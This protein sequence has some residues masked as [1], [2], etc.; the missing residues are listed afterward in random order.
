MK[1]TVFLIASLLFLTVLAL[2]ALAETAATSADQS[3]IEVDGALLFASGPDNFDSGFG[4]N[5]GAGYA[6]GSIDKNLQAR[7]DV[8]FLKFSRD[9]Y[10]LS[11]DYRRIPIT[12]GARYY[13][14]LDNRLKLFAQAGIETS[15]DDK[16][17]FTGFGKQSKS[18]LNV[19]ITPGGG[20]DFSINSA[21]SVFALGDV[22]L[23]SDG[24]FSL[25]LG[26]AIH[27]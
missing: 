19:G 25:Q 15:F 11:L 13:F 7:I 26:C 8:G 22:H 2:P 21:V 9:F 24:Y 23:I 18:E 16:D 10:G 17:S 6:L 20:V 5:F 3:T 27:F 12:I 4:L 1:K 14:P